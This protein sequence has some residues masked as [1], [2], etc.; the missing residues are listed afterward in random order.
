[1]SLGCTASGTWT[2]LGPQFA[3]RVSAI[4]ATTAS[5]VWVATPGGGVWKSTDGG[6]T[7]TWAGNY[8]LGDFTA[9]HL[10]LDRND[11]SRMYL[12]TVSG[13]LVSTDGAAHWTR[14]LYS[15]PQGDTP[16]R[17]RGMSARRGR[18]ARRSP[19]RFPP[20]GTVGATLA[21]T[22]RDPHVTPR[23][24]AIQHRRRQQLHAALA[25][26]RRPPQRNPI[27]ASTR[28]RSTTTRTVSGSPR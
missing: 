16:P 3:G 17:I 13:V 25:V 14:T 19:I 9:V 1:M 5:N 23:Q 7:F 4:V 27:C 21:D 26:Q 2:E 22:E 8:A 24:A 20:I 12:R 10:A 6:A 18:P 28:S 15:L 11:P